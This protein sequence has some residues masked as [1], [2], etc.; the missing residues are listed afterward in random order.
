MTAILKI[1]LVAF[2]VLGGGYLAGC[3]NQNVE[4]SNQGQDWIELFNGKDLSNWQ[5]KFSGHELAN[6]Y[7]NTF[8][9]KDGKLVVSYDNYEKFDGQF[10]H[11][12][13]QQPFS[14][15]KLQATYR[16]VGKQ[17]SEGP[18]WAKRN[19]GFMIHAQSADSMTLDQDFPSS[20]EVQL[21]GGLGVEERSTLNIC[22]PN[23]HVVIEGELVTD[24]CINSTSKTFHGD[25]WVTIEIEVH[26]SERIIH[27]VEGD[28]VFDYTNPQYD[29]ATAK[30]L[31]TANEHNV[32]I[33]EGY[34]AIQAE[35]APIEFKSIRL[36]PLKPQS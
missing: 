34:I 7:L 16:F 8:R 6:N 2:A 11:L 13:Y 32:L 10:G 23:T 26:G 12:F 3:S 28:I 5:I 19:N 14:H 30:D 33:G 27:K 25:Q 35:T 17:V 31:I 4:Q 1:S 15:Y 36:Q 21:L 22:T 20:I 9:V 29:K 24:H 18:A